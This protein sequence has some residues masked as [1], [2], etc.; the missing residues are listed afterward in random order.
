V[1]K[2]AKT[3]LFVVVASLANILMTG[4]IFLACLAL[5]AWTLG[6]LL[7]AS[8]VMWAVVFCFVISLGA[9]FVLYK[10]LLTIAQEKFHLEEKI[11]I[12]TRR[13]RD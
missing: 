10:K 1:T 9:T 8:A 2:G 3:A 5:Y 13:S 12:Q 11:G 6:K 4:I 7:P